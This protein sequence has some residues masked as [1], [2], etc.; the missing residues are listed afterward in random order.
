VPH[1]CEEGPGGE[2]ATQRMLGCTRARTRLA[3][4]RSVQRQEGFRK[5]CSARPKFSSAANASR[6]SSQS[7]RP[8]TFDTPGE[9]VTRIRVSAPIS[10]QSQRRAHPLTPVIP[11][12]HLYVPHSRSPQ[13]WVHGLNHQVAISSRNTQAFTP[14]TGQGMLP[15]KLTA[16]FLD[17][18]AP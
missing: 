7:R 2:D 1:D 18:K 14:S 3:H 9:L 8:I 13:S 10:S 11:G 15:L 17:P 5:T 4:C 16:E 6:K 12:G